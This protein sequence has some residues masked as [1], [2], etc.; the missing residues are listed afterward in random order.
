VEI[1][2]T[3]GQLYNDKEIMMNRREEI[4]ADFRFG[5]GFRHFV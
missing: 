1:A 3:P 5:N 2:K 4:K